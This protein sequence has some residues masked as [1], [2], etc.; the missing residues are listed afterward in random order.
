ML[1]NLFLV[2]YLKEAQHNSVEEQGGSKSQCDFY[3]YDCN[4]FNVF[5]PFIFNS[6]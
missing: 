1:S 2:W 4:F 6:K 3:Q 5:F